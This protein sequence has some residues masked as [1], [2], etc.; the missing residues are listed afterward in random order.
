MTGDK[1]LASVAEASPFAFRLLELLVSG[2]MWRARGSYRC[3][4][5]ISVGALRS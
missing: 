2:T 5:R 4:A 3:A 1:G